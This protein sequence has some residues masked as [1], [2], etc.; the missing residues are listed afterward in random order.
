MSEIQ[1]QTAVT[2][3]GQPQDSEQIASVTPGTK[4]VEKSY[5]RS[6]RGRKPGKTV[7]S[8]IEHHRRNWLANFT[9]TRGQKSHLCTLLSA[10][11]SLISHLIAG[12]RTFTDRITEQIEIVS[13]LARG[14]IDAGYGSISWGPMP[15]PE[16]IPKID[17]RLQDVLVTI[18]NNK[19]S[20]GHIS[21]EIA[22][23][24]LFELSSS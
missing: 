18:F 12:R 7:T 11:D 23:N 16:P 14:T 17:K 9:K 19:L 15:E 3:S 1:N 10:P 6:R 8:S 24:L 20:A 21:N 2:T 22:L 5:R 13:R 4:A